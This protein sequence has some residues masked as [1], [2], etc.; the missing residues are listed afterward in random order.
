MKARITSVKEETAKKLK[1]IFPD[2]ETV[3]DRKDFLG[4]RDCP[5]ICLSTDYPVDYTKESGGNVRASGLLSADIYLLQGEQ[6]Q[7]VRDTD[8]LVEQIRKKLS[9]DPF[10]GGLVSVFFVSQIVVQ[11]ATAENQVRV[12]QVNIDY[13][14]TIPQ[15]EREDGIPEDWTLRGRP[16]L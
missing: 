3:Q 5:A 2:I 6:Y 8:T 14:Y 16:E 13:E 12:I 1:S 11:T 9:E 4:P 15:E 7:G 10:L